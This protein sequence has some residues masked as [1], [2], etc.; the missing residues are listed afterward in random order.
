M[1]QHDNRGEQQKREQHKRRG[2]ERP[3]DTRRHTKHT[4]T[5]IQSTH[6]HTYKAHTHTHTHTQHTHSMGFL[7]GCQLV[8]SFFSCH[9]MRHRA[10][11]DVIMPLCSHPTACTPALIAQTCTVQSHVFVTASEQLTCAARQDGKVIHVLTHL[12]LAVVIVRS[13]SN[14]TDPI[15]LYPYRLSPTSTCISYASYLSSAYTL[16]WIVWMLLFT[17]YGVCVCH[18]GR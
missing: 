7:A 4:H 11:C 18:D 9:L 8:I 12:T 6:T 2:E 13:M 14:T 3:H 5:H 10:L 17:T 15:C 16:P 1:T